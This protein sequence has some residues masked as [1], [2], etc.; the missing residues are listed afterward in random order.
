MRMAN[1]FLNKMYG[2]GDFVLTVTRDFV[3]ACQVPLLV[4]PDNIPSHPYAAA[5]EM[6][7]PAPAS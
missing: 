1:R 2:D 4:L 3:R 6:T 7:H 5:T